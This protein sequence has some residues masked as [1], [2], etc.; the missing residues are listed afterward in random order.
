MEASDSDT[1]IGIAIK[2][3]LEERIPLKKFLIEETLI[4]LASSPKAGA[5]SMTDVFIAIEAV[6]TTAIEHPE[7]DLGE[8]RSRREWLQWL[9]RSKKN[10]RIKENDK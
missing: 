8:I 6:H 3:Q 1:R 7:W 4:Q 9:K 2:K 10:K 5:R